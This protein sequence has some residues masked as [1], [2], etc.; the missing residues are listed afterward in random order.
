MVAETFDEV[1]PAQ[2]GTAITFTHRHL[3]HQI[4]ANS[5]GA[6]GVGEDAEFDA[7]RQ[8]IK[9]AYTG[10]SENL[11]KTFESAAKHRDQRYN[12]FC[13]NEL[14]YERGDD[15]LQIG[16]LD[17][18]TAR[19]FLLRSVPRHAL[20]QIAVHAV[21]LAVQAVIAPLIQW[22]D[23]SRPLGRLRARE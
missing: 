12:Q 2:A 18:A 5:R 10:G 13:A 11:K 4:M 7:E 22:L 3:A 16:R 15:V 20:P 17:L 6:F 8:I 1:Y 21:V 14:N 19:G 9:N 23:A